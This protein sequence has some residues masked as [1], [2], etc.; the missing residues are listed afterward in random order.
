[1]AVCAHIN[2]GGNPVVK[3]AEDTKNIINNMSNSPIDS[4][5]RFLKAK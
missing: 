1:M 5:V 2:L 4:D 3:R